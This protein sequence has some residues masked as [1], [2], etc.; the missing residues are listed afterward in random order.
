[1]SGKPVKENPVLYAF[2]PSHDGRTLLPTLM[3]IVDVAEKLKV[4]LIPTTNGGLGQACSLNSMLY[5]TKSRN[6]FLPDKIRG[7]WIEDDILLDVS[8]ADEIAEMVKVA[9]AK[10][11]NMVAPYAT[12]IA[13]NTPLFYAYVHN[14]TDP[15]R[16]GGDAYTNEEIK[17]LKPYDKIDGL[18]GLGFYY[19][20]I[21]LNYV[22]YEGT[23]RGHTKTGIPQWSGIDWN[24]FMDNKIE[25]RHYPIKIIHIKDAYYNNFELVG[26]SQSNKE[27]QKILTRAL[28]SLNS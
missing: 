5:A 23:L 15:A 25:L 2:F 17:A 28:A 9:E 20:D 1:M 19:G 21:H 4:P 11:Y 10:Q 8:Q 16:Y 27:L 12:T 26:V 22:F 7:F 13:E 6:P 3:T 18:A 24:Y 14:S